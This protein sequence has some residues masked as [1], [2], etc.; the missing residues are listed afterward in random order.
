MC[1]HIYKLFGGNPC[2]ER[3]LGSFD[4]S[5]PLNQ[6]WFERVHETEKQ[7]FNKR[8]TTMVWKWMAT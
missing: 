5:P 4:L 3:C 2:F 1:V 6:V 7:N 8:I